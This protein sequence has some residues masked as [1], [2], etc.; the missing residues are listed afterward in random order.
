MK[1]NQKKFFC[2]VQK[3]IPRIIFRVKKMKSKTY[4]TL[5]V[6][7][8][9]LIERYCVMVKFLLSA[10]DEFQRFYL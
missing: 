8:S 6:H 1:K 10:F 9:I 7:F 5:L 2:N 4:F 3:K